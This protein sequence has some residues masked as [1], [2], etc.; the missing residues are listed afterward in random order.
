MDIW[1][2]ELITFCNRYKNTFFY[3]ETSFFFF[4]QNNIGT[5][6]HLWYCEIKGFDCDYWVLKNTT[7]RQFLTPALPGPDA[8]P[9][10]SSSLPNANGQKVRFSRPSTGVFVN[11]S[12]A[13]ITTMRGCIIHWIEVLVGRVLTASITHW[14]VGR[15]TSITITLASNEELPKI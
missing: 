10:R 12:H 7:R 13:Q 4:F 14:T 8:A 11:S 3:C 15:L 5:S 1:S 6:V 9:L 2:L